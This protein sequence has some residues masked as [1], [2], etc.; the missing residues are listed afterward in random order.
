MVRTPFFTLAALLVF[1]A[2]AAAAPPGNPPASA[3]RLDRIE[4]PPA[5]PY[6][7]KVEGLELPDPF[8]V[9][10][11]EGFVTLKANCKGPVEWIVRPV[12]GTRPLRFKYRASEGNEIDLS[13]PPTDCSIEVYAIGVVPGTGKPTPPA[14]TMVTVQGPSP[15]PAP[16]PSPAP[17]PAAHLH[18]TIVLDAA[19]TTA[20]TA[21][22]LNS[23]TLFAR[24]RAAGTEPRAYLTSDPRLKEKHL[25]AFVT[26]AGGAPA[27]IAQL[28]SGKVVLA[29]TLPR[30]EAEIL[31]S[32]TRAQRGGN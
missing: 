1:A 18:V 26:R 11:D 4:D 8:T 6:P 23:P 2:L 24:L 21:A 27:L 25:D 10:Y 30:T 28:D 13:I 32:I 7:N 16:K 20:E 12:P 22:L 9:P 3:E 14:M 5:S 17:A 15:E 29:V 19:K 31:D